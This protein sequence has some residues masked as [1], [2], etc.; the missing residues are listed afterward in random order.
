MQHSYL[1][2]RWVL[3]L[4]EAPD[5]KIIAKRLSHMASLQTE[6]MIMTP[7]SAQTMADLP[8]KLGSG[9]KALLLR[10]QLLQNQAKSSDHSQATMGK[11][12]VLHVLPILTF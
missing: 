1:N 2:Y 9:A 8:K 7:E 6:K 10:D 11:L 4:K 5:L 12:P 3:H